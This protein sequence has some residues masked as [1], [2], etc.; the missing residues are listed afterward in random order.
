[1]KEKEKLSEILVKLAGFV[2]IAIGIL[3]L[4]GVLFFPSNYSTVI[5]I[6]SI[7]IWF[8]SGIGIMIGR[9][10]ILNKNSLGKVVVLICGSFVLIWGIILGTF[11]IFPDFSNVDEILFAIFGNL[12]YP[13]MAIIGAALCWKNM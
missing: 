9:K 7:F 12:I 5:F 10:L 4:M 1:M 8:I 6:I 3:G 13:I 2:L 11:N